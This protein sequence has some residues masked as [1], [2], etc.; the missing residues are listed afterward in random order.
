MKKIQRFKNF[1]LFESEESLYKSIK[2]YY[3]KFLI[4][5]LD[6]NDFS[7]YNLPQPE[8]GVGIN[9]E[10]FINDCINLFG[11]SGE[12]YDNNLVKKISRQVLNE[13]E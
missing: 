7:K 5:F 13:E 6:D 11:E 8:F 3:M 1:R 12:G 10:K 4:K 9:R 2:K